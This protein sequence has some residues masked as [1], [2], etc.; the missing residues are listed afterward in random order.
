MSNA[1]G[2]VHYGPQL[3]VHLHYEQ[4]AGANRSPAVTLV[5]AMHRM[6]HTDLLAEQVLRNKEQQAPCS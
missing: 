2:A 1:R 4:V 3:C 5:Y 6:A